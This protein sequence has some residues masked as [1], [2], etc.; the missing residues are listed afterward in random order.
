MK[1]VFCFLLF[2]ISIPSVFSQV[3]DEIFFS[4]QSEIEIWLEQNSIY[5]EPKILRYNGIE[6]FMS[7]YIHSE[8]PEMKIFGEGGSVIECFGMGKFLNVF[9]TEALLTAAYSCVPL[10]ARQTFFPFESFER[11]RNVLIFNPSILLGSNAGLSSDYTGDFV[12]LTFY[13]GPYYERFPDPVFTNQLNQLINGNDKNYLIIPYSWYY[14]LF[15][16]DY[17]GNLELVRYWGIN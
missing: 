11:F 3:T 13:F 14:V 5:A 2:M 17:E 4:Y 1:N 12:Y 16:M 10:N 15:K 6:L 7:P 9:E 8:S